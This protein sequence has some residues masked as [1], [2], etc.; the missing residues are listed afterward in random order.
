[1]KNSLK[2]YLSI[3][4]FDIKRT[5]QIV[6]FV[7]FFLCKETK[8]QIA[9]YI[10]N[11]SFEDYYDCFSPYPLSKA[12]YWMSIDSASFA[13]KFFNTCNLFVPSNPYSYQYPRT[14]HSHIASTFFCLSPINV[15]GYLKNRL[16]GTL[17][18]GKT[19]CVKFHV[20]ITDQS[21]RGMDG[22]GIYFGDAAIDTISKCTI[23]LSYINPQI[24]NP[25]GNVVIDTMNWIPITGTFVANGTEKYAL[26][27]NFLAD[28][29]VTTLPLVYSPFYP[30][31]YTDVLIDD[32]SCVEIGAPAYAGPD[33]SCVAGD[34]VFIG[35]APDFAIDPGCMWYKLPDLT[36]AIDTVSGFWVKPTVTTTYVVRQE[37]ECSALKWDTVVIFANPVGLNS[38]NCLEGIKIYPVPADGFLEL[39]ILSDCLFIDFKKLI[40]RNGIGQMIREE[41]IEFKNKTASVNTGDLDNGV[42]YLQLKS[43]ST[44]AFC[45]KFVIA[46]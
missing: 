22:F 17:Q 41:E 5:K 25:I 46:R 7:C 4:N 10:N 19:Y 40:I 9:N 31:Y 14:G 15:R 23:P 33:Q 43:V 35:R 18:A 28:N 6:V 30:Q 8:A 39:R 37:L 11:G 26:I 13:G 42:Y 34:S 20:N 27:G 36:T 12:K 24:K 16:K 45:K 3:D 38:L 2:N 29:A 32:V 21:P 44:R 1:M